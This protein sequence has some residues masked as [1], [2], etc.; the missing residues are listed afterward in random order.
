MPQPNYQLYQDYLASA[1]L[2]DSSFHL[3]L[4]LSPHNAQGV[5]FRRLQIAAPKRAG[6]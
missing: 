3:A 6:R 1:A 2:T 4:T 5:N